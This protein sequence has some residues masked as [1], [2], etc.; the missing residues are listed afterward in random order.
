[1]GKNNEKERVY[2][3][4]QTELTEDK[5][6]IKR[7]EHLLNFI[8]PL[9][10]NKVLDIGERNPLTK[11]IEDKFGLH[12]DNTTGDLDYKLIVS[13]RGYDLVVCS[14]VIEHVM[15]PLLLVENIKNVMDSNGIL[16]IAYPIAFKKF[17]RHFNEIPRTDMENL[18]NKAGFDIIKWNE[19]RGEYKNILGIPVG[20]RPLIRFFYDKN[21]VFSASIKK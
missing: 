5:Y 10:K 11:K 2:F 14:H 20:L 15:N 13:D 21:I 8:S 19:Y 7:D 1:L 4:P 6:S 17:Y 3:T 12:A 16:V 18:M 9:T